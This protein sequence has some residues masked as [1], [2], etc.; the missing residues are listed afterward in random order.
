MILRADAVEAAKPGDRAVFTGCLIVVPDVGQ[1][2]VAGVLPQSV[3]SRESSDPSGSEGVK[4][5]KDL[6]TARELTYRLC[7]L[8]SSVQQAESVSSSPSPLQVCSLILSSLDLLIL[9]FRS[10]I[11]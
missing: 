5:I 2:R 9:I 3:S 4:G 10:S 1:L 7:F 8:A 6:G 11:S